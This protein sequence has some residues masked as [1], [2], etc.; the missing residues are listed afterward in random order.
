MQL[1]SQVKAYILESL[2]F[3]DLF[4]QEL[5]RN[6]LYRYMERERA[7]DSPPPPKNWL[8]TTTQPKPPLSL[9][10]VFQMAIEQIL[11]VGTSAALCLFGGLWVKFHG[12]M[13]QM[14]NDHTSFSVVFIEFIKNMA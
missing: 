9:T 12:F 13:K 10:S 1:A 3:F 11:C 7:R 14:F 8:F 5:K 4:W 6:Y 2:V